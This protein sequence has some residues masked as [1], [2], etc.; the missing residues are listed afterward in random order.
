MHHFKTCF[1]CE[2]K[3]GQSKIDCYKSL[4]SENP[5]NLNYCCKTFEKRH[6]EGI[7]DYFLFK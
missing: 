3:T 2:A 7:A 4:H 6:P 5:G 1:T